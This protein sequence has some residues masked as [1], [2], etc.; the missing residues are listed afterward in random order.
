MPVFEPLG[1]TPLMIAWPGVASGTS[2]ALTTT[3]D[4]FATLAD[5]FGVEVKHRT[6]GKSL[7]PLIR[8]EVSSVRDYLLCG[9]WG[10]EVHLIDERYKY[11]RAPVESNSPLSLWSNRWSTMPISSRPEVRLPLPN[12]R[13]FLDRMPGSEVPVIRQP[14][15]QGDVLPYWA[16]GPFTGNHLYDLSNDPA[17]DENIAGSRRENDLADKLR[18]ALKQIEAPN[19]QFVRLGME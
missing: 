7:I 18:E 13:A 10:R 3:V 12:D 4:L 15:R 1:H 16:G 9:M 8:G 5:L 14:Y 11:V 2:S 17:E 6:H 19:D